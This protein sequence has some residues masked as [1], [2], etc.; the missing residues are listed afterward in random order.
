[1]ISP[2]KAKK[3]VDKDEVS[4]EPDF[5][6]DREEFIA[7]IRKKQAEIQESK[8]INGQLRL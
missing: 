1:M 5:I 8:K 7:E 2:K 3:R 6:Q 4:S